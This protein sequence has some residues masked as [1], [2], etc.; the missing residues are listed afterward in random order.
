MATLAARKEGAVTTGTSEYELVDTEPEP[1]ILRPDGRPVT[2]DDGGAEHISQSELF[3]AR[4]Q[5]L[6]PITTTDD[7]Q[8]GDDADVLSDEHRSTVDQTSAG[9]VWMYK[10]ESWGWR[11]LKVAKNSVV[12]LL[13]AGFRDRCGTCGTARCPGTING[14]PKGKMRMYRVCPVPG[15]NDG[16]PKVIYDINETTI[17][18]PSDDPFAIRDDA[19]G[20]STPESR[21]LA[22]MNA[23]IRAFHETYAIAHG[24]MN[25]GNL[26]V[27]N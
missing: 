5:G 14:C 24:L 21:T 4:I 9:L 11:R 16:N 26:Q 13:R 1:E 18:A 20:S 15:C 22:D 23:H 2:P 19:Y 10:H 3:L 27:V 7:L 12:E 25:V 6:Q 17:K 8:A